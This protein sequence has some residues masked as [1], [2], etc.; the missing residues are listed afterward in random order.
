METLLK[1]NFPGKPLTVSLDRLVASLHRSQILRDFERCRLWQQNSPAMPDNS[2][3][4]FGKNNFKHFVLI[5]L[6]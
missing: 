3:A 1:S 4:F 6:F 5:H 2:A